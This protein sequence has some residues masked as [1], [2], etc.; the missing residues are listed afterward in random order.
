MHGLSTS[1]WGEIESGQVRR[2]GRNLRDDPARPAPYHACP[3]RRSRRLPGAHLVASV[4]PWTT[5]GTSASAVRASSRS[6][7]M[8]CSTPCAGSY[9]ERRARAMSESPYGSVRPRRR[10]F[11]IEKTVVSTVLSSG[12]GTRGR[13]SPPIPASLS[14]A[15]AA[16]AAGKRIELK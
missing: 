6:V 16:S 4:V 1:H 2:Y 8:P 12:G 11:S 7:A 10:Y 13:G 14:P 15:Q 9:D 3:A 5:A